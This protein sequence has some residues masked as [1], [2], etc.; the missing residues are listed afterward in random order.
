MVC[1]GYTGLGRQ[2]AKSILSRSGQPATDGPAATMGFPDFVI[3]AGLGRI[4]FNAARSHALF[5]L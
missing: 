2:A 1:P 5:L 4:P 3:I